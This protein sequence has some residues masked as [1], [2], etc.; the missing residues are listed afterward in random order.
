[1]IRV[2]RGV[3]EGWWRQ[4]NLMSTWEMLWKR[5]ACFDVDDTFRA[6]TYSIGKLLRRD[7]D[8]PW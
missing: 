5:A 2:V 6:A 7:F 4:L 8:W 1:M 3:A